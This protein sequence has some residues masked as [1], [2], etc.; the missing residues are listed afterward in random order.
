MDLEEMDLEPIDNMVFILVM[1]DWATM[2]PDDT[3]EYLRLVDLAKEHEGIPPE[4]FKF[5]LSDD[6][7]YAQPLFDEFL[8]I[9]EKAMPGFREANPDFTLESVGGWG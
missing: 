2:N 6:N 5:H 9:A 4:H 8:V 3:V 1:E 7:P